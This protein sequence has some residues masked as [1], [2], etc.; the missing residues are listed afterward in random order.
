MLAGDI[1]VVDDSGI[2]NALWTDGWEVF[3][4]GGP[5]DPDHTVLR[6]YPEYATSW[7]KGQRFEFNIGGS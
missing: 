7:Y 1:E 3:Y 6:L 2:R 4:P 5:D